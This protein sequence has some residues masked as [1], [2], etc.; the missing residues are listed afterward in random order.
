MSR[1]MRSAEAISLRISCMSAGS[2]R[3]LVRSVVS[4]MGVSGRGMAP[5]E[6]S[7]SRRCSARN[8]FSVGRS[9]AASDLGALRS[10]TSMSA[11]ANVTPSV[12]LSFRDSVPMARRTTRLRCMASRSAASGSLRSCCSANSAVRSSSSSVSHAVRISSYRPS[13]SGAPPFYLMASLGGHTHHR[14]AGPL[15][16]SSKRDDDLL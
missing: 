6:P 12:T 11:R 3:A 8:T 1:S 4:S 9:C 13:G 7:G 16:E 2:P 10:T 15:H 14:V 5:G